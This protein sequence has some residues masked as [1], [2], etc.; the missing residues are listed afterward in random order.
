MRNIPVCHSLPPP[1][2]PPLPVVGSQ[3][4]EYLWNI[5]FHLVCPYAEVEYSWNIPVT[6]CMPHA[7]P[8][9]GPLDGV[10]RLE[11]LRNIPISMSPE[12]CKWNIPYLFHSA[13]QLSFWGVLWRGGGDWIICGIFQSPCLRK[14]AS[15]IFLIYSTWPAKCPFGV[16]CG[17]LQLLGN[18][19]DYGIFMEYWWN[20]PSKFHIYSINIPQIFL[21]YW[22]IEGIFRQYSINI[23]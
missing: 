19:H 22:N 13:R 12:T 17:I 1:Q 5:P 15:G 4:L 14:H 11:Y 23:P 8:L 6:D 9:G 7:P 20:M 21:F 2:S 16:T 18:L 10:W 3:H